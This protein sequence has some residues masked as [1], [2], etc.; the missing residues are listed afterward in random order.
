MAILTALHALGRTVQ[1]SLSRTHLTWRTVCEKEK[2]LEK[3]SLP[4]PTDKGGQS[5]QVFSVS[6]FVVRSSGKLCVTSAVLNGFNWKLAAFGKCRGF[7]EKISELLQNYKWF[8]QW[9]LRSRQC[10]ENGRPKRVPIEDEFC[11]CA[12]Y[13]NYLCILLS[14]IWFLKHS[15]FT[16]FLYLGLCYLTLPL[17]TWGLCCQKIDFSSEK[18]VLLLLA[19]FLSLTLHCRNASMRNSNSFGRIW[20]LRKHLKKHDYLSR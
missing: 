4:G 6:N 1:H 5:C 19:D 11:I 8:C 18:I 2:S 3:L 9:N 7:P 10:K 13:S 20:M 12:V 17:T 16:H 15:I 14:V